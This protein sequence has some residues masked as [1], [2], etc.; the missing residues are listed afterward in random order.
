MKGYLDAKELES[1]KKEDLQELAKQ[2]GVDAEGTKKEIAARCAAVEV[3][4]PDDNELTEEDK[5]AAAEA[6][7]EAAAKAEEEKAAAEAAAKAEEEKAAAGLVKV[8]AQRRFLDKE[9]NQIK[10]TGDVYTVSRERAAVL[11]E[12]GVAEVAE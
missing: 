6:A 1:Y 11:K 8:K 12:A 4:I 10:D 5:K 2:L 7:A 9:L 3:D